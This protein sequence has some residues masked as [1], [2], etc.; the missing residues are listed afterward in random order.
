MKEVSYQEVSL[1]IKFLLKKERNPCKA[2]VLS[3]QSIC[4]IH[5]L[6]SMWGKEGH[7][8]GNLHGILG[9]W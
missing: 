9:K 1:W 5:R 7:D 8:N 3:S 2:I 4:E 6:K